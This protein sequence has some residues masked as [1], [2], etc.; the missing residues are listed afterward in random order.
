MPLGMPRS[1]EDVLNQTE[2]TLKDI[3]RCVAG[4]QR[5]GEARYQ[6][7]TEC[8]YCGPRSTLAAHLFKNFLTG[9][10]R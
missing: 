6:G 10:I 4:A 8:L 5:R 1:P 7:P 2:E 9:H 3:I